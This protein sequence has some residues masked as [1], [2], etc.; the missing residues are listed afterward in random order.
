MSI[1]SLL[2]S[3]SGFEEIAIGKM[4]GRSLDSLLQAKEN[5]VIARCVWT[6]RAMRDDPAATLVEAYG[7]AQK[8]TRDEL[9][10]SFD[11]PQEAAD[12]ELD[13]TAG[14]PVSATGK[15][16]QTT[17]GQPESSHTSSSEPA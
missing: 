3:L 16:E 7:R 5:S 2:N 12:E 1:Q 9:Y 6:V 4:A 14:E 11:D 17:S 10:D 13:E 8:L 15:D